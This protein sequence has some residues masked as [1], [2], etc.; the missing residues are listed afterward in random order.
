MASHLPLTSIVQQGSFLSSLHFCAWMFIDNLLAAHR[1]K[2]CS[3]ETQH[4]A[5]HFR[6]GHTI[7]FIVGK[8]VLPLSTTTKFRRTESVHL[9]SLVTSHFYTASAPRVVRRRRRSLTSVP[10]FCASAVRVCTSFFKP[11]WKRAWRGRVYRIDSIG[12]PC[13]LHLY[14]HAICFS[15]S[16]HFYSIE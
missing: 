16:S 13:C 5:I 12:C 1:R 15:F 2:I 4:H 14:R 8:S 10:K 6:S 7:V 3:N 11:C 9:E